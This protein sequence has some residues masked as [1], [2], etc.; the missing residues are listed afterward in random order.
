MYSEGSVQ[1]AKLTKN[2]AHD[3]DSHLLT[4]LVWQHC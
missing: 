1:T 4:G 3:I 2:F